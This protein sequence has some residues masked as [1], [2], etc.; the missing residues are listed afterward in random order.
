MNKQRFGGWATI[1]MAAAFAGCSQNSTPEMRNPP[2]ATSGATSA[3]AKVPRPSPAP[4]PKTRA[5]G[6]DLAKALEHDSRLSKKESI[7]VGTDKETI[8]LDGHVS[9]AAAK[10]IAL[11]IA[12]KHARGYKIINRLKVV[13]GATKKTTPP[14]R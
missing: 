1:G 3:A 8:T 7:S 14:R 2:R 11:G 5:L 9:S 4:M 12:Q 10:A 6:V 13:P